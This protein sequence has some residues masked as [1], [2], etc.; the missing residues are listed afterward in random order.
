MY[1]LILFLSNNRNAFL[2]LLLEAI[3]FM[4]VVNYNDRYY[5]IDCGEGTQMQL[6]RYR[7]LY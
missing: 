2:F 3:A 1:K 6:Q 4:L 7:Q 5:L